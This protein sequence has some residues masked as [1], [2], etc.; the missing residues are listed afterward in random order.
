MAN[1][2]FDIYRSKCF[3]LANTMVVHSALS[4]QALNVFLE[5]K[6]FIINY[7]DPKTWKYYMNLAGQY[8]EYDM[9]IIAE[10]NLDGHPFMRI[11][12]AGDNQPIEV[13]FKRELLTGNAGDYSLAAEYSYGSPY[14]NELLSRY[15][16]CETLILGILNPIDFSISTN[17]QNGDILY[18]GGYYRRRLPHIMKETYGFEKRDDVKIDAEFLIEEWEQDMIFELESYFKAYLKRWEVPDFAAN[19]TYYV[20]AVHAGMAAGLVPTI[21]KI[22]L[23]NRDSY[24]VHSYHTREYINSYG[25]LGE[26]AGALRREQVMYLYNNMDWL[27]TNKGK[28]KVLKALIDNLLTPLNVPM[29]AYN[30]AHDTWQMQSDLEVVNPTIE[31]KK[32]YLNL[33]PLSEDH[34][35]SLSSMLLKEQGI[36]R[37][38]GLYLQDEIDDTLSV[39]NI[40]KYNQSKTKVLESDYA[41]VDLNVFFNI[42]EFQLS[43]WIYSLAYGQYQ[44]SI[45]VTNP[46]SGGRLQLTPK[47]AFVLMLYVTAKGYFNKTLDEFPELK[48]RNIPK[49]RSFIPPGLENYPT[50]LDLW[51]NVMSPEINQAKL[52]KIANF[53]TIDHKF[54]SS[55]DFY[56]KTVAMFDT[57]ETRRA[58]AAME[59]DI[60]ANGELEWVVSKY[61]H[62][63]VDIPPLIDVSYPQWFSSMG[64]DID[65]L[66]QRELRSLADDL[67]YSGMGISDTSKKSAERMH[68]ALMGIVSFFLSY[69]VQ[70]VSNY[71]KGQSRTF[72]FKNLRMSVREE[73][74]Q[75]TSAMDLGIITKLAAETRTE[76][77]WEASIISGAVE[78]GEENDHGE[79]FI[80]QLYLTSNT[81]YS[82]HQEVVYLLNGFTAMEEDPVNLGN[83]YVDPIQGET[84][85]LVSSTFA[86][87]HD[88]NGLAL[89]LTTTVLSLDFFDTLGLEQLGDT[90]LDF[91]FGE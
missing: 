20:A 7:N 9:R 89:S 12:V 13:D 38:N 18:C 63:F 60:F 79:V 90:D 81:D 2:L 8:H 88:V 22:R 15:P 48:V 1:S 73:V 51:A 14:Y 71:S 66:T 59:N 44:G 91:E 42:E 78:E 58:Y 77:E 75:S 43:Q 6:G 19:H 72:G 76:D 64:I 54:T 68:D 28:E 50:N 53:P 40:S 56:S 57:L 32:E 5:Q 83:P 86:D 55:T 82:E 46:V 80:P 87:V 67:F 52:N 69:T 27:V 33:D 10:A 26:F 62:L 65:T 47:T 21:E 16:N 70:L 45:F 23:R 35:L 39:A 25:Y 85:A 17:A 74:S 34:G 37:D 36:G 49:S 30:L 84:M 4:A 11:K 41:E 61:Y 3:A 24:M 31:F 29:V